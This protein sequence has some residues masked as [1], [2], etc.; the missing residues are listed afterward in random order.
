MVVVPSVRTSYAHRWSWFQLEHSVSVQPGSLLSEG[1]VGSIVVESL[2]SLALVSCS[3]SA[4]KGPQSCAQPCCHL[5][6][7][8]AAIVPVVSHVVL[9][10]ASLGS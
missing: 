3:G 10:E 8:L 4:K 9:A 6:E 2:W 1:A 5:L 7:C